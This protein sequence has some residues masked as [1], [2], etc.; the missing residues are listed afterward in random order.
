MSALVNSALNGS[1]RPV[2]DEVA[3]TFSLLFPQPRFLR[4]LK[5][6][7]PDD[8][9]GPLF[10]PTAP[11]TV[12]RAIAELEAISGT[13]GYFV[14]LNEVR[15][16]PNA[17]RD[18]WSNAVTP[19]VERRR[20]LLFDLDPVRESGQNSAANEL[21]AA[22]AS[23][24]S[25]IE[26]Q[27]RLGWPLP[28]VALSGNG[29]HLLYSVDLPA[30]AEIN[31]VVNQTLVQA[32]NRYDTERV[33]VDRVVWDARRLVRLYGTANRKGPNTRDRPQRQSLLLYRPQQ[34]VQVTLRDLQ[35]FVSTGS[36]SH[37]ASVDLDMLRRKR[38]LT[39]GE[40]LQFLQGVRT[41]GE[42]GNSW[43]AR[44]PTH[45]DRTA[46]LSVGETSEGTILLHCFA[47]CATEL[48]LQELGL[49]FRQLFGTAVSPRREHRFISRQPHPINQGLTLYAA[50]CQ[51][52]ATDATLGP[53]AAELRLPISALGQ[54]SIGWDAH[55]GA[56]T[57]PERRFDGGIVG[58]QFRFPNGEKRCATGSHRGLILPVGWQS[59]RGE[60]WVPEGASDVAA[61]INSGVPAIGRPS[62]NYC[63]DLPLLARAHG[64]TPRIC[65]ENDQ[66]PNGSWPGRNGALRCAEQVGAAIGQM[67]DV[68]FP[69]VGHKDVREWLTA[70][71]R[72]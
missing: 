10:V 19:P 59:Y 62:A 35:A 70:R 63:G 58:V 22:A 48:I 72:L 44:C 13:A 33:R 65:G 3:R 53:L 17:L 2:S 24:T 12:V 56:W 38:R 39:C 69:P 32:A 20:W 23:A 37:V 64:L 27:R 40:F 46:S 11:E 71:A 55:Q 8:R 54:I 31:S 61:L 9:H 25:V 29:I 50:R 4:A 49:K 30:T 6:N 51:E 15:H 42:F 52:L 60:V 5:V 47:G 41:Q 66:H 1:P 21:E 43:M 68:W 26:E 67:V 34:L 45:P 14:S 16:D 28:A 18:A 57:I 7:G 36:R